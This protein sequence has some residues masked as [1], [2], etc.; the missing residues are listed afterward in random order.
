M[1][2]I[3][4]NEKKYLLDI[5]LLS[6]VSHELKTPL[7]I[8][9]LNVEMLKKQI[10]PEKKRFIDIMDTEVEWMIQFISDTLD[11]QKIQNKIKLNLKWYKWN[12]WMQKIQNSL[13]NTVNLYK[14]NLKL[15]FSDKE[16]EVYMDPFYIKQVLLNLVLNAIEHSPKN[17][18]VE[19]SWEQT[20][21][22]KL[23]IQVIDQGPGI[24]PDSDNKIFE[25]FYKEREK[26]NHLIKGSGLGL[27]IAKK[28]IQAHGE[29]I[30]AF[31]RPKNKGATFAF[32]L[33]TK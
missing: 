4:K 29:S 14:G 9:K 12:Q 8:L 3:L 33:N 10:P 5:D 6:F 31:N 24:T 22:K 13:E 7:S 26:T 1:S 21:N 20:K 23:K 30:S 2:D 16:T 28:I 25:P 15:H 27:T 11:V 19:I 18:P 32:T 17:T